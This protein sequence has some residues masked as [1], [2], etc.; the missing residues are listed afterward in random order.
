MNSL[1]LTIKP[2]LGARTH[3]KASEIVTHL[4]SKEPD[5]L[6]NAALC[7]CLTMNFP[8]RVKHLPTPTSSTSSQYFPP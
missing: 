2:T 7:L 1:F 5:E 8:H 4:Y 6:F 3:G